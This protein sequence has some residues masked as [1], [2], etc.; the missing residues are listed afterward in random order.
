MGNIQRGFTLIELMI[1][2]AIIGILAAIAIPQFA[3]YRVRAFN[4][5]ALA[6]LRNIMTAEEAYY[7]DNQTYVDFP[8]SAGYVANLASLP[9][10][11]LALNVCA[12]VT[13]ANAI[14]F[15]VQAEHLN[16]DASYTATQSASITE[17]N[18]NQGVY[19]LGC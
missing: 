7:A 18:K 12:Q 16:G 19:S 8:T 17:A 9:G 10:A 14:D 11:N 4:S 5:T 3:E 15:T 6:D 2:V 13:G 1:V